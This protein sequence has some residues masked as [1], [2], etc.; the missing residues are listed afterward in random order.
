M[1]HLSSNTY[2]VICGNKC[3][4]GLLLNAF[5]TTKTYLLVSVHLLQTSKVDL[6]MLYTKDDSDFISALHEVN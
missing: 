6:Y 3:M 1:R 4:E 5:C 2:R